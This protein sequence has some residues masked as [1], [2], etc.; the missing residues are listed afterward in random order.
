MDWPVRATANVPQ[1][2]NHKKHWPHPHGNTLFV[3]WCVTITL[4]CPF[5]GQG[6]QTAPALLATLEHAF[7]C[8]GGN[9]HIMSNNAWSCP[10]PDSLLALGTCNF[11]LFH[12]MLNWRTYPQAWGMGVDNRS[13]KRPCYGRP[14]CAALPVVTF[15]WWPVSRSGTR[16]GH[17]M[18]FC[19]N[20]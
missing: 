9:L 8:G 14:G 11:A 10:V 3:F 19:D 6:R 15:M 18:L 20:G 2:L 13:F 7:Q 12:I 4:L 16:L 5:F 1:V 17:D